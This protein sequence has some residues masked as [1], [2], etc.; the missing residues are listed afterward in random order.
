MKEEIDIMYTIGILY[1]ILVYRLTGIF[2]GKIFDCR[3]Q[4]KF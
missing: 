2:Y 4:P 1:Y 3:M